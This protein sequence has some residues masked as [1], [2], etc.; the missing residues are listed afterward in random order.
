MGEP[1][2]FV[3]RSGF[4]KLLQQALRVRPDGLAAFG[5]PCSSYIFLNSPTHRRTPDTPFGNESLDY[6]SIANLFYPKLDFNIFFNASRM[7]CVSKV[8]IL[9]GM[10]LSKDSVQSCF[11]YAGANLQIS[12]TFFIEQPASS[13]L[14]MVPYYK[15]I[16]EVC[17]RFGISFRNSFLS[18]T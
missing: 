10:L 17:N 5:I 15:F 18:D 4:L 9:W 14:F 2:L 7:L 12:F 16:Q 6:V 11:N 13:R 3:Q 8:L 1:L